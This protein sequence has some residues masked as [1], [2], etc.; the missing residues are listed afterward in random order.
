MVAGGALL[1]P[2]VVDDRAVRWEWD[3]F[4]LW[5]FDMHSGR[6]TSK[7]MRLELGPNGLNFERADIIIHGLDQSGDSF[8]GRVFLNNPKAGIETALDPKNGYAGSFSVY[9]YGFWPG[10]PNKSP[11]DA[12]TIR[13]PIDKDV[14]ATDSIR[15]AATRNPE[16]TVTIVPVFSRNPPEDAGHALKLEDVSIKV[17]P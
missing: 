13:A 4:P 2:E 1:L 14:I 9:G 16:I 15:A 7:P 6:F 11:A 17:Y 3:T 10:E 5:G 8:E 12:K